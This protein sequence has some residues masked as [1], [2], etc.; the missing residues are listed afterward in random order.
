VIAKQ[1]ILKARGADAISGSAAGA[2][3]VKR[4]RTGMVGPDPQELAA[5]VERYI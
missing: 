3:R 2:P 5:E 4:R 1:E